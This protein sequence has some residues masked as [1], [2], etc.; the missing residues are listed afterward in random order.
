MVVSVV[1]FGLASC[2]GGDDC[3]RMGEDV[4]A[5]VESVVG[6]AARLNLPTKESE[7]AVI[8]GAARAVSDLGGI[9]VAVCLR[10]GEGA[11]TEFRVLAGDANPLERWT[12]ISTFMPRGE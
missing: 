9:G 12:K 6:L 5:N 4:F 8:V 11:D 2:Y 10:A 7:A 1:S 3:A